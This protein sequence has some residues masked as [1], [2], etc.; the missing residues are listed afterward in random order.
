MSPPKNN[1][2]VIFFAFIGMICW[3]ITPLFVKLGLKDIDPHIGLAIR[4][5]TTTIILSGWMICDGSFAR[6]SQVST[7]ALIFL[8]LEAI[9]ATFIGDLA[10]FAAIKNGQVSLVS[11]IL[12]A[13]PLVTI[14][15]SM[16][17]LNEA[18][19]VTR[20]IGSFLI[21]VGIFLAL[22]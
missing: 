8:V 9:V 6:I 18:V 22:R 7:V 21:I 1:L 17:F 10:Y 14:L 5:A 15:L 19:T 13:S 3:G 4:T 12:S 2:L 11:I 16:I 20:I